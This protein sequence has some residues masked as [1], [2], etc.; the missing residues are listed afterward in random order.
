LKAVTPL[1]RSDA[2]S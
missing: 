1:H 2:G